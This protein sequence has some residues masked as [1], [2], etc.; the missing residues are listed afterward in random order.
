[1]CF[2]TT[3]LKLQFIYYAFKVQDSKNIIFRALALPSCKR[4]R[5]REREK[6]T[7]GLI[8]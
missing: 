1:V 4:E 3:L 8:R 6:Y 5:E 2:L 7:F